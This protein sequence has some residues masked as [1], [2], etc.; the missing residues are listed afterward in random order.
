MAIVSNVLAALER[1]APAYLAMPGD[2]IGLQVGDPEAQVSRAVISLDRSLS[3][4]RAAREKGA[5]L[6]ISH[7]PLIWEPLERLVPEDHAAAT[8]MECVKSGIA[9]IAAHT[10]WDAAQGGVNDA[11]AAKLGLVEVVPFGS[12][13]DRRVYKLVVFCPT[14]DAHALLDALSAAGAGHIGLYERCAFMSDGLG[15][16]RPLAGASPAVGSVG[17][18]EDVPET[19]L[20]TVV[21]ADVKDAVVAALR[22]AHPYEEPAFDIYAVEGVAGPPLGRLGRLAAPVPCDA[23]PGY[24]EKALGT[25]VLAWPGGRSE[26][27]SKVAVVGGSGDDLWKDAARAGTDVLVTGEVKQHVALEATESGFALVAAGHYATEQPGCDALRDRLKVE[28]PNVEWL[29]YEP[30]P[31]VAGRPL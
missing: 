24:V 3:A 11:L 26:A 27:V 7:H 15:N 22:A 2:H 14:K 23:F 30:E 29:P 8:A 5:Q 18:V 20:E 16:F 9:F 1:I 12:A 28:M 6:L 10:N 17:S 13:P 21:P 25:R 31:G 4:V 19:R